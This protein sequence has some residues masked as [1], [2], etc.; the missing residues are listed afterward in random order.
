[1]S[2]RLPNPF[3][4]PTGGIPYPLSTKA[5]PAETA[6]DPPVSRPMARVEGKIRGTRPRILSFHVAALPRRA[7]DAKGFCKLK[8]ALSRRLFSYQSHCTQDNSVTVSVTAL[9]AVLSTTMDAD[10]TWSPPMFFAIT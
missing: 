4:S 6:F 7:Y 8:A 10:S 3:D 5:V 1:M 9:S 2:R